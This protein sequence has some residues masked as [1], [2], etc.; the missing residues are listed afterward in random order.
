MYVIGKKSDLDHI[1]VA[2]F[3]YDKKLAQAYAK[4]W[5]GYEVKVVTIEVEK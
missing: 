1:S 4:Q 5:D 3:T 2:L